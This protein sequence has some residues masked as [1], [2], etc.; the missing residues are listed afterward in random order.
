[1]SATG[2]T[3]TALVVQHGPGGGLGRW[4]GWL[5]ERGL[6]AHVVRAHEGAALPDRLEH[7]A[8]IVLGGGYLPD[9]DVRAPWLPATRA[10]VRQALAARTPVFGICLGGQ[11]LAQVAGGEVRGRH[12]TPEFGSTRLDL[13]PEAA[14]DPL[15]HGLPAR[16]RAI[17]NHVDAIT[18]LPPGAHWLVGGEDCPYQAFRVG[19]S[20][21]GVQFHPETTAGTVRRWDAGRLAGH[22]APTPEVLYARALKDEPAATVTWRT[23]AH[24]FADV[25][26]SADR[27]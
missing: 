26:T 24:R 2:T 10:L 16:P 14:D 22:G 6:A 19:P 12:G 15:F 7:P 9:D 5:E 25:V 20:A 13:R 23:V 27:A 3:A 8:L 17:E 1:M 21:W 4:T 18:A 11:M